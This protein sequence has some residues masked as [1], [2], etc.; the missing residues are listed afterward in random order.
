MQIGYSYKEYEKTEVLVMI[1][2]Y[3]WVISHIAGIAAHLLHLNI[4]LL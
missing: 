2:G 1:S 3:T 4:L